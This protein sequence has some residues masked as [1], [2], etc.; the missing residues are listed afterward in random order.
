MAQGLRK[1]AHF[2]PADVS[3]R[4]RVHRRSARPAG[5][6]TA[7]GQQPAGTTRGACARTRSASSSCKSISTTSSVISSICFMS[8][9]P[10]SKYTPSCRRL[11]RARRSRPGRGSRRI[12]WCRARGSCLLNDVVIFG[13]VNPSF[14]GTGVMCATGASSCRRRRRVGVH[15]R[16][17]R[18]VR[19]LDFATRHWERHCRWSSTAPGR[20]QALVGASEGFQ[21]LP[22]EL[23]FASSDHAT[24]RHAG[25][26]AGN[27]VEIAA[28]VLAVR[29]VLA[30][31]PPSAC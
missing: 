21:V 14:L 4:I 5:R 11:T 2:L 23:G 16:S 26:D 9:I 8:A 19:R 25:A 27:L 6:K 13:D 18:H 29:G 3:R 22:T 17:A 30:Q 28:A 31:A 15:R 12:S 7:V 1:A 20:E 10:P 24:R